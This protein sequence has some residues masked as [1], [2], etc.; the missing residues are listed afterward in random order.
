[1]A[2]MSEIR[3]TTAQELRAAASTVAVALMY[4]LPDDETWGKA[5]ASWIDS[6]SVTAWDGDRCVGHAAAYRVAT[7]VPGG[8][9]L[10]TA[11]VCRVGVLPTH[12]RQGLASGLMTRVLQDAHERGQVL[13]SLRATEAVIYGRWGF[14]IAGEGCEITVDPAMAR[15]VRGAASGTVRLLRPDEVLGTVMPIYD[16][17]ARAPGTISRPEWMWRRYFD[18]ALSVGGEAHYVA[19]HTD[20]EG[21]DDGY[22]HYAVKWKEEPGTEPGGVGELIELHGASASVRL[23]LW[24]YL[25]DVDLVRKWSS[26]ER[27]MDDVI[28]LGATDARAVRV[29]LLWDEQWVRLLHVDAAL[30]ARTYGS[31]T[32]GV[33]IAVMDD[34]FPSNTGVWRVDAKGASRQEIDPADADLATDVATLAATYLGGVRWTALADVGRVEVRSAS[35]LSIAD[36][37]FV[38]AVAPFCGS[39][40]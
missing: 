27:P 20:E 36:A 6:D 18:Q 21:V 8:A 30:A 15:P 4:A 33:T 23:A 17:V 26:D 16:R 39:F 31:A 37:L 29:G 9:Q 10:P 35:A 40:F 1:M 24:S 19:V 5:E 14:G 38:S 11:A 13:A 34:L 7:T 2:G 3:A 12:R 28:R 22:V 32:D 25:C